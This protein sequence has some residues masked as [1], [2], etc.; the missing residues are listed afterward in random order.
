MQL[1]GWH[2]GNEMRNVIC[3]DTQTSTEW[4]H[5]TSGVGFTTRPSRFACYT[6]DFKVKQLQNLPNRAFRLN[7]REMVRQNHK[8][9]EIP[10]P[11]ITFC[12]TKLFKLSQYIFMQTKHQYRRFYDYIVIAFRK[13]RINNL[14]LN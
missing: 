11:W 2:N 9:F 1:T 4:P 10:D 8:I 6:R 12:F 13:K 7:T 14:L 3:V 5:Y